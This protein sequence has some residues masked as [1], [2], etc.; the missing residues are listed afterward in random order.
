MLMDMNYPV[1]SGKTAADADGQYRQ[2]QELA[3]SEQIAE[4][5]QPYMEAAC[6][7][8]PNA[9]FMVSQILFSGIGVP[10]DPE[11]ALVW[12]LYSAEIG[13]SMAKDWV[14]E[15]FPEGLP[16]DILDILAKDASEGSPAGM[17]LAGLAYQMCAR[18]AESADMFAKG[19][20]AG[21]PDCAIALA[22]CIR[23]GEGVPRD[24]GKALAVLKDAADR[25]FV[26]AGVE[27]AYWT[28]KGY[29]MEKDRKQAFQMYRA[30][31]DQGSP[32]AKYHVGR[33]FLDGIGTDE[34]RREAMTWFEMSESAG[35]AYGT[36]GV[37]RCTLAG[38]AGRKPGSGPALLEKAFE[39]GCDE[40]AIMLA[41][42][43]AKDGRAVKKDIEKSFSWYLRAAERGNAQAEMAVAKAYASGTGV[44][45]DSRAAAEYYRRAGLHGNIEALYE[46]GNAYLT[47]SGVKKDEEEGMRL[48]SIAAEG[49]FM[50]AEYAVANCYAS[51]KGVARDRKKAFEL[52]M[53]LAEKG[54]NRSMLFVGESLYHGDGVA[55]DVDAAVA[56][57]RKGAEAKNVFCMYW[58]GDACDNGNGVPKDPAAA[59]NWYRQAAEQGHVMSQ[60][61]IS[62]REGTVSPFDDFMA[63]AEAG[64]AQS[65]YMVGMCYESGVRVEKDAAKAREWYSKAAALGNDAAKRALDALENK[66]ADPSEEGPGV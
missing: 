55:R 3:A 37:A 49:G 28:E 40:A 41:Q 30:A 18:T 35:C 39:D 23:R 24:T 38:V 44:K 25:G 15:E 66:G 1:V 34:D 53:A 4:A 17:Y 50:K 33:C 22:D 16:A 59:M 14:S 63:K 2:A 29:G 56:W 43:Y 10:E 12:A 57:F 62:E 64:D 20:E 48:L 5:Y 31:A 58:M 9:A 19:C 42:L 65:M 11:R 52:H 54:Y 32:M 45:K 47:G 26:S 21:N 60:R 36:F 13:S 46:A 61:I 8:N 27:L 7:G 6:L 51:G